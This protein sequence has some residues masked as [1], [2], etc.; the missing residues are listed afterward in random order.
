MVAKNQPRYSETGSCKHYDSVAQ[1]LKFQAASA[2][3]FEFSITSRFAGVG[4]VRTTPAEISR[5]HDAA[6][7]ATPCVGQ[8]RPRQPTVTKIML[9]RCPCADC[10]DGRPCV[11][12]LR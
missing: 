3:C 10:L 11:P 9:P 4:I 12:V 7:F 1:S 8:A 5:C 2:V 6:T